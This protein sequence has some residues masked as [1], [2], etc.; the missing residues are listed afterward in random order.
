MKAGRY[1][2]ETGY[3]LFAQRAGRIPGIGVERD[4]GVVTLVP[5][6]GPCQIK[7]TLLHLIVFKFAILSGFGNPLQRFRLVRLLRWKRTQ[8]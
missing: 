7:S 6:K 3:D 4:A 1:D 8:F 5:F 2:I